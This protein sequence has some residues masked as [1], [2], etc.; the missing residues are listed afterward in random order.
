MKKVTSIAL[1]CAALTITLISCKWF[2]S[3]SNSTTASIEGK[4]KID[5]ITSNKTDS[6]NDLTP[7]FNALLTNDSTETTIE[8]KKD[9][10][11]NYNDGDTAQQIKYYVGDD[12]KSLFIQ[13]DSSYLQY[14][15][16]AQTATALHLSSNGKDSSAIH[17]TKK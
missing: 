8:F 11:A 10:I 6:A 14:N 5:S 7:L 17:L 2:S 12:N 15:I 9:S 3:S 13:D 1:I 16:V 4:W